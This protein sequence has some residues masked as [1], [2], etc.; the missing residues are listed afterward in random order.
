MLGTG[1]FLNPKKLLLSINVLKPGLKVADFGCGAGYFTLPIAEIVGQEGRVSAV[2]ILENVLELISSRAKN[3]GL[4]NIKT[5][6]ANLEA[7]GG[8]NLASNTQDVVLMANVLFQ[9]QKKGAII[10]EAIR[11]TKPGG[12]IVIIEWLPDSYFTTDKGWRIS[13][14][15]LKK[16]LEEKGLK[17]NEE[18]EPDD[19][20]Y[21]L[22]Y[23]KPALSQ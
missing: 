12:T 4:F 16:I 11:V 7:K 10:D 20:H 19:Y 1:G 6:H 17:F 15:E 18:F 22:V 8:S 13:P 23:Q 2:D 9:S 5:I 3:S 21:G 14:E